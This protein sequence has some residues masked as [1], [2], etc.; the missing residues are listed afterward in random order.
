MAYQVI[1]FYLYGAHQILDDKLGCQW[2]LTCQCWPKTGQPLACGLTPGLVCASQE[3]DRA[4]KRVPQREAKLKGSTRSIALGCITLCFSDGPKR[5]SSQQVSQSRDHRFYRD[6]RFNTEQVSCR[7]LIH[8]YA[9][10]NLVSKPWSK[11]AFVHCSY[12]RLFFIEV[13][14]IGDREH[15]EDEL[16]PM[17][18]LQVCLQAWIACPSW[19]ALRLVLRMTL[20]SWIHIIHLPRPE[21]GPETALQSQLLYHLARLIWLLSVSALPSRQQETWF[22]HY[23][24]QSGTP[25]ESHCGHSKLFLCCYLNLQKNGIKVVLCDIIKDSLDCSSVIRMIPV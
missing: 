7:F 18:S 1:P 8:V 24:W 19:P 23:Y 17:V 2:V 4:C 20:H 11:S 3:R 16:L 22:H 9:L 12:V 14:Y 5:S 15:C 10:E 25:V 13:Q 6:Q 21:F